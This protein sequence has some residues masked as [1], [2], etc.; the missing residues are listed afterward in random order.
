MQCQRKALSYECEH[1]AAGPAAGRIRSH[2]AVW[3]VGCCLLAICSFGAPGSSRDPHYSHVPNPL[4]GLR[5][6][7]LQ[8]LPQGEGAL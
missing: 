7:A 1:G 4:H 6:A 2:K 3:L 5:G 8:P